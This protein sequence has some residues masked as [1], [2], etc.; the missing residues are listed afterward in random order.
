MFQERHRASRLYAILRNDF[1]FLSLCYDI[2]ISTTG[3]VCDT[4]EKMRSQTDEYFVREN[5]KIRR[6]ICLLLT[7]I[8]NFNLY[9]FDMLFRSRIQPTLIL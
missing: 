5:L 8:R 1:R 4:F 6:Y 7:S 3:A 2:M 9:Y